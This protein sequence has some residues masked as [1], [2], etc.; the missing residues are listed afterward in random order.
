MGA[1]TSL[2][3]LN[4]RWTLKYSVQVE[5]RAPPAA[6][7]RPSVP[8]EGGVQLLLTRS[9]DLDYQR[10]LRCTLSYTTHPQ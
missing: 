3:L 4:R 9:D 5:R 6:Q 2:R 8:L 1:K 7:H 10:L